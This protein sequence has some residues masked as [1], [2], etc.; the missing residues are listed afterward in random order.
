M[1][2]QSNVKIKGLFRDDE[3]VM[4]PGHMVYSQ[5]NNGSVDVSLGRYIA[6]VRHQ[7]KSTSGEFPADVIDVNK[8]I[9]LDV[10]K[11]EDLGADGVL[12]L[13]RGERVLAHTYEFVGGRRRTLPE[14]R[15]K[16]SMA[17]WG[18]TVCAC[19]GWGDV[20]YFNRW[21]MEIFNM[22][23]GPVQIAVGTLVA[24]LVFHDVG[25]PEKGTIYNAPGAGNYQQGDDIERIVAEWRPEDILPKPMKRVTQLPLNKADA[26]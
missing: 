24:Q 12:R 4:V 6:R 13:E 23:P 25:E 16:S 2:V 11:I 20:G 3:I 1:S 5:V 17:R 18:L 8:H 19:A 15:A 22:N 10:F 9:G 14:M 26:R 21:T 7:Y